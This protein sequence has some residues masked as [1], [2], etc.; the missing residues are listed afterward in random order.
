MVDPFFSWWTSLFFFLQNDRM[1]K[2]VKKRFRI[3][4]NSLSFVISLSPFL[5]FPLF[6]TSLRGIPCIHS[7]STPTSH[8]WPPRAT[9]SRVSSWMRGKEEEEEEKTKMRGKCQIW[10][11]GKRP[12]FSFPT[13]GNLVILK[14]KEKIVEKTWSIWVLSFIHMID[15]ERKVWNVFKIVQVERTSWKKFIKIK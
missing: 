13:K 6:F 12:P 3:F 10:M 11:R 1:P 2:Q 8:Q 14:K 15:V 9:A 4:N 5:F 7:P